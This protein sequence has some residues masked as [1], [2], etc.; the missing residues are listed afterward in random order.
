VTSLFGN[1][2]RKSSP[3]SHFQHSAA[4]FENKAPGPPPLTH[5][6]RESLAEPPAATRPNRPIDQRICRR[7]LVTATRFGSVNVSTPFSKFASAPSSVTSVG[8]SKLRA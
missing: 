5:I 3:G 8:S 1:P 6:K 4:T 2:I 7:L